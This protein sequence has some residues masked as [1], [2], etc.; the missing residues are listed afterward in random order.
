MA[1][2]LLGDPLAGFAVADLE[3]EISQ[4]GTMHNGTLV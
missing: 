1:G 2:N 3:A 4:N